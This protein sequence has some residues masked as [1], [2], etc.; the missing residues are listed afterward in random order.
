MG[1]RITVQGRRS[2]RVEKAGP[3]SLP[4]SLRLSYGAIRNVVSHFEKESL[5]SN[6][7]SSRMGS[8][9]LISPFSRALVSPH[10]PFIPRTIARLYIVQL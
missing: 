4:A 8:L 1:D 3:A 2:L 9:L 10:S 5:I 7:C 6:Y